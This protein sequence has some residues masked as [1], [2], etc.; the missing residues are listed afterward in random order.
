MK[1]THYLWLF[2]IA[3][4]LF[5]SMDLYAATSVEGMIRNATS[6]LVQ[7][8]VPAGI[9]GIIFS[10]L[11]FIAQAKFA[12][13]MFRFSCIGIVVVLGAAGIGKLLQGMVA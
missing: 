2:L 1:N 8:G 10:G 12:M 11:A 9:L 4:C 13:D 7:I 6:K 5:S 3:T